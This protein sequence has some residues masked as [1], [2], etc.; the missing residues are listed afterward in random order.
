MSADQRCFCLLEALPK[1]EGVSNS[2][3]S[4][5]ILRNSANAF[6]L[7]GVIT[8]VMVSGSSLPRRSTVIGKWS[9]ILRRIAHFATTPVANRTRRR[10]KNHK[11][12]QIFLVATDAQH[13]RALDGV[14][15]EMPAGAGT[16]QLVAMKVAHPDFG[17]PIPLLPGT[18]VCGGGWATLSHPCT[19]QITVSHRIA[20]R[21]SACAASR[22]HRGPGGLCL[23][24]LACPRA[25][26]ARADDHH[27]L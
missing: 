22:F 26:A 20:L 13:P 3:Y 27:L 21:L 15:L 18:N 6:A 11:L 14:M 9:P 16:R 19:S 17:R 8:R 2:A 1:H 25:L 5:T 10:R 24:L 23:P 12:V 7:S 4:A